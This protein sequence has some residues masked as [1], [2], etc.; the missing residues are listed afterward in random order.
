MNKLCRRLPTHKSLSLSLPRGLTARLHP[1]PVPTDHG[2]LEVDEH[3][4]RHVLSGAGLGEE[5]VEGVVAAADRLVGGHLS[6]GLDA[7]LEAVELPAGVAHL[8]ARLAHVHG[9]AFALREETRRY[10]TSGQNNLYC[11]LST[12]SIF[13]A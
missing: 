2:G 7:V 8:A 5:G 1:S 10:Q 4:A 9:D 13:S 6:V 3:S 11:C 12:C